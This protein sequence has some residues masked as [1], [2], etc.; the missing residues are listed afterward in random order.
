MCI[1]TVFGI[2]TFA[3]VLA[4]LDA[5][6]HGAFSVDLS[7]FVRFIDDVNVDYAQLVT[8]AEDVKQNETETTVKIM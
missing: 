1:L 6:F 3:Y 5:T 2:S 8:S 7:P 4:D